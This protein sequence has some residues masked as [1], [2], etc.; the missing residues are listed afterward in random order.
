MVLIFRTILIGGCE[1]R[2]QGTG[3]SNGACE[4]GRPLVHRT[5]TRYL[6]YFLCFSFSIHKHAPVHMLLGSVFGQ[7][8]LHCSLHL[9]G[10]H[11]RCTT[12][13]TYYGPRQLLRLNCVGLPWGATVQ[14]ITDFFTGTLFGASRAENQRLW[15]L[16]ACVCIWVCVTEKKR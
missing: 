5:D 11:Y 10:L 3:H 2:R 15:Q 16:C 14:D 1:G 7:S 6:C 8:I 12:W 4:R 13:A 9:P